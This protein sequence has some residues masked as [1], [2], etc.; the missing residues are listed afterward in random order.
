MSAAGVLRGF[1]SSSVTPSFL[2]SCLHMV[3][4]ICMIIFLV[5]C[6]DVYGFMMMACGSR[7]IA[8]VKPIGIISFMFV[9]GRGRNG[10]GD[11]ENGAGSGS[12]LHVLRLNMH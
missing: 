5:P 10:K 11:A 3:L 1:T 7:C 6:V 2:V 8:E 4:M 9:G 12:R